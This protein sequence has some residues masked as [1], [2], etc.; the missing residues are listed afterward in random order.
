[1]WTEGVVDCVAL[2]TVQPFVGVRCGGLQHFAANDEADT[3]K[4][5]AKNKGERSTR[6][7]IHLLLAMLFLKSRSRKDL[8]W[9]DLADLSKLLRN[10]DVRHQM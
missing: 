8:N 2:H 7:L 6:D 4:V 10:L 9:R 5:N 3:K 1:M